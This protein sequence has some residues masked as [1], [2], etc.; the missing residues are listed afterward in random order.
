MIRAHLRRR[1]L[2][3]IRDWVCEEA[4]PGVL[5]ITSGPP[6]GPQRTVEVRVRPDRAHGDA[7]ERVQ[8]KLACGYRIVRIEGLP[9]AGPRW[10]LRDECPARPEPRDR[11]EVWRI[12]TEWPPEEDLF[13]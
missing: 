1:S 11:E 7:S 4:A 12:P 9:V 8:R 6:D 2:G 13:L 3:G 10:E 5:R